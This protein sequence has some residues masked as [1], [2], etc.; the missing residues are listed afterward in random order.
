M[1]LAK[2][3]AKTSRQGNYQTE[4]TCTNPST[5][6]VV[7]RRNGDTRSDYKCPHAGCGHKVN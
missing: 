6:H 7:F 3:D 2:V 1:T 4:S 5:P